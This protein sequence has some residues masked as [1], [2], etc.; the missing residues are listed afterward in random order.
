MRWRY[1]IMRQLKWLLMI[2]GALS[3][4]AE[5]TA[6]IEL[7]VSQAA[8]GLVSEASAYAWVQASGRAPLQ[9]QKSSLGT[10]VV[11]ARSAVGVYDVTF[12]GFRSDGNVQVV[13]YGS[14]GRCKLASWFFEVLPGTTAFL[15][16]VRAQV[17]CFGVGAARGPQDNAFVISYVDDTRISDPGPPSSPRADR[18]RAGFLSVDVAAL[19]PLAPRITRNWSSVGGRFEVTRTPRQ[20]GRYHVVALG[21][22]WTGDAQGALAVTAVGADD[23]SYCKIASFGNLAGGPPLREGLEVPPR[24]RDFDVRCFDGAGVAAEQGFSLRYAYWANFG[25]AGTGAYATKSDFSARPTPAQQV[26]GGSALTIDREGVGSYRVYVFDLSPIHSA[27]FA[28][29]LGRSTATE[30]AIG[31]EHCNVESW[32]GNFFG[33]TELTLRCYTPTGTAADTPY[34]VSYLGPEASP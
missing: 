31:N 22:A 11:A 13:A 17:R 12:A 28:G 1:R 19:A 25:S 34:H 26:V 21:A 2:A 16:Q 14:N 7:E 4:T 32:I 8:L 18:L 9:Y 27:A 33:V 10:R 5:S 15:T 20:V 29:A 30:P 3:C 6:P 24:D 23:D